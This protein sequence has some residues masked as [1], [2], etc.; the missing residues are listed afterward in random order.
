MGYFPMQLDPIF[1]GLGRDS[2]IVHIISQILRVSLK[3]GPEIAVHHSL[4]ERRGIHQTEVHYLRKI[5][6]IGSFECHFVPISFFYVNI[7]VPPSDVKLWEEA[8]SLKSFESF[9]DVWQWIVIAHCP[10]VDLP[11]VHNNLFLSW[12]L[13]I[14][15]IDWRRVWW[16]SFFY[17]SQF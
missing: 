14:Y 15:K 13:F 8:F 9:S 6:S 5:S 17:S 7:I 4:K 10:F 12:V 11:I 3:K 2:P 1:S 16:G